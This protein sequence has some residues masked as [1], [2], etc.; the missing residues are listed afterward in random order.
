MYA[1]V[2]NRCVK[3]SCCY[4]SYLKTRCRSNR[5]IDRDRAYSCALDALSTQQEVH[6]LSLRLKTH[7]PCLSVFFY[8]IPCTQC[9]NFVSANDDCGSLPVTVRA[10]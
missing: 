10:C 6:C 3:S 1:Y 7:R 5:F 9:V 2:V 8:A 4:T